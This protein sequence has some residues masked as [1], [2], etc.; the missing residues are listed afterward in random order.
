MPECN[1]KIEIFI[2]PT[3]EENNQYLWNICKYGF[4]AQFADSD[5][6][7]IHFGYSNSLFDAFKDA[8]KHLK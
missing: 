5:W 1:L 2:D 6:K 3:P 8:S 7:V 4:D